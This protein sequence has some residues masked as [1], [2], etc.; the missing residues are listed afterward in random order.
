MRNV[1][2]ILVNQKTSNKY[3]VKDLEEDFHT[4]AG[5]ISKN[6]LQSNK[7]EVESS[8]GSKFSLFNP[9]FVDFWENLQRGPQVMVQKDIGM[10]LAKT[11]I[12][13]ESRIVDAGG[14]SGSLCLSLANICKEITVYEINPEH[15]DVIQ[16][17]MKTAGLNNVTLKQQ[18][19]YDGIGEENLDLITLDLPEPWQAIAHAEKSLKEGGFLVVYLP[20]L[21]QMKIL[22]DALRRSSLKVLEI[23]ELIER[24]WKIEDKIMRPEFQMLGH[25]GFLLFCRKI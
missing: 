2:K 15:Y 22:T 3:F 24:K 5:I 20:N 11:G 25:T 14:G 4:A 19:V 16:K 12:N 21:T 23:L 8:T 9:S 18:S 13:H 7:V 10:I 1:Q 17:N 6:D